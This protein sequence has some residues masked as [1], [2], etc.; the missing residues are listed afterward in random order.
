MIVFDVH[1]DGTITLQAADNHFFK[2]PSLAHVTMD[3]STKPA[4]LQ[5]SGAPSRHNCTDQQKC[6]I[7]RMLNGA[8][9]RHAKA[10]NLLDDPELI[11]SLA[12]EILD[13][14][15]DYL[16]D[17]LQI[18]RMWP[19]TLGS[20]AGVFML[21]EGL[22]GLNTQ[23]AIQELRDQFLSSP[24]ADKKWLL[25]VPVHSFE[26]EHWTALAITFEAKEIME[27]K[28]FDSLGQEPPE[29]REK[30]T[31]ILHVIQ[32]ACFAELTALPDRCN[33]VRQTDGWSCGYH[34]ISFLKQQCSLIAADEF[35]Q[36]QP[37]Q[38]TLRNLSEFGTNL[39]QFIKQQQPP[40][41]PLPP[42]LPPPFAPPPI[43][44]PCQQS[45]KP[46]AKPPAKPISQEDK[47]GCS[48]CRYASTGCFQCNPHKAHRYWYK[49]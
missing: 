41:P 19:P 47:F 39:K 8:P 1:P 18:I 20:S 33:I 30:A 28:Y 32:A 23:F 13:A 27:V 38:T 45:A 37:I 48:K 25:A 12:R 46:P 26:P 35:I 36:A 4:E 29:S 24:P 43:K 42:P 5:G 11:V 21:T 16:T 49:K 14:Q 44:P 9:I 7:V 31:A 17:A 22:A 3:L 2:L 40:L 15:P 34:C 10:G 6:V